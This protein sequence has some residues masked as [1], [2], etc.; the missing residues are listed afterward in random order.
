MNSATDRRH[1]MALF[2]KSP[3]KRLDEAVASTAKLAERLRDAEIAVIDLR[4]ESERLAI[5]NASD[6]QLDVAEAR[7]RAMVDRVT[8]LQSALT[9]SKAAVA[10][11]ERERDEAADRKQREETSVAVEAL[12]RRMHEGCAKLVADAEALAGWTEK[13]AMVVG[14]ANGVLHFQT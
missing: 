11:L 13:A 7:T 6:D 10:D 5:L 3:S 9:Q 2:A 8:T 1:A 4:K 12:A 14:E